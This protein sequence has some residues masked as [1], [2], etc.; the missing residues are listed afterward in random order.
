MKRPRVKNLD[1]DSAERFLRK[2]DPSFA[3]RVLREKRHTR[4]A[5]IVLKKLGR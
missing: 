2:H 5:R 4:A 3:R 1:L